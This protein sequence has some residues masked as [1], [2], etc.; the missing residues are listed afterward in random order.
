MTRFAAGGEDAS[1][2]DYAGD[3]NAREGHMSGRE[4]PWRSDS[5]DRPHDSSE[6]ESCD[7][8]H[9]AL[10]HVLDSSEPGASGIA[11]LARVRKA[12]LHS[13]TALAL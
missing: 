11:A 4:A 5:V 2:N 1:K 13:L 3:Q 10:G 12:P 9:V 8:D 6:I 7:V